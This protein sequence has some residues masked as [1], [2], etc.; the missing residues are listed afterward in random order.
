MT[1]TV[2][3]TDGLSL[4]MTSSGA[5]DGSRPPSAYPTARLQ[6]GLLLSDRGHDL[7]EEGVGFAVP[8]LKLGTRTVFPGG[9]DVRMRR[10]ARFV[11][12]AAVYRLDLVERLADRDGRPV[13]PAV[14]YAAKDALAALHRRLPGARGF[15]TSASGAVRRRFGWVTTY[16]PVTAVASVAVITRVDPVAGLLTVTADLGGLRPRITE[17]ALMNEQ[18]AGAFDRYEED[19]GVALEGR[20]I[21]AWDPVGAGG[22]RFVSRLRGVAFALPRPA[23]GDARRGRELVGARLSWAGF[24]VI[25]SPPR[26]QLSYELCVYRTR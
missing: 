6:R 24:A 14:M 21:G 26:G 25:A 18:G 19:G 11:E 5:R 1:V 22:G 16:V 10:A 2:E 9:A 13:G 3:L 7:S 17:V 8:V 4:S 15:L 23:D 12:I 20:A